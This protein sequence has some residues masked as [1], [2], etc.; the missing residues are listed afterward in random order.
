M[1]PAF[2]PV[3]VY[4]RIREISVLLALPLVSSQLYP[5][6][7]APLPTLTSARVAHGL[8]AEEASRHY[9]I[10]IQAVVTY[11]DPSPESPAFCP[12]HRRLLCQY[13]RG[14]DRYPA[15]ITFGGDD[16]KSGPGEYAPVIDF[17]QAR[18]F[19]RSCHRLP[20]A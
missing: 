3:K 12:L 20:P 13:L 10:R 5:L 6:A 15:A 14:A 19:P 1:I 11:Y 7:S 18:H 17:A 4:R 9:P 8:T 2:L 16:R